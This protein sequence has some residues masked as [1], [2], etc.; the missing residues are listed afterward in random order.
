MRFVSRG[1]SEKNP[2]IQAESLPSESVMEEKK[3][4]IPV[5]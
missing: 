3:K 2:N 4:I 1:K 5:R